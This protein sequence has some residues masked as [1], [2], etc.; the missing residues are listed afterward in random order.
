MCDCITDVNG[1]LAGHNAGL[2]L[3]IVFGNIQQGQLRVSPLL[4]VKRLD[5][6][7]RSRL[8]AVICRF[9]PICGEKYEF[10]KAE[11]ER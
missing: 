9:C 8:P 5:K 2:D 1:T 10:P 6:Q 11:G 7:K 3:E 4:M